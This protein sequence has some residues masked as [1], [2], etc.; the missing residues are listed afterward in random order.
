MNCIQ[1]WVTLCL[2]TGV[3]WWKGWHTRNKEAGCSRAMAAVPLKLRAHW[4]SVR[5]SYGTAN[6]RKQ[7]SLSLPLFP[8]PIL[9]ILTPH[10]TVTLCF[11]YFFSTSH[12]L[13]PLPTP[14]TPPP[15]GIPPLSPSH[16]VA[17]L[18]LLPLSFPSLPSCVSLFRFI[19]SFIFSFHSFASVL[20]F[21]R[22]F[23]LSL[24][25]PSLHIAPFLPPRPLPPPPP[26]TAS[27]IL[28]P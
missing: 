13:R 20:P 21:T 11:H 16:P 6:E 19:F 10:I 1:S 27:P 7:S 18:S 26:P 25:S 5:Q 2:Y 17:P 24:S 3:G 15:P 8:P 22:A 28:R 14:I 12:F 4:A 23:H 9:P